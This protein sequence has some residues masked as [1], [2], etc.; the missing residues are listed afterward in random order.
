M[1]L[2]INADDFGYSHEVNEAV[3]RAH[4][5]GV[6]T[7]ASLMAAEPGFDHA[8]ELARRNPTLGVGLHI[9]LTVDHALLP[10]RD[11]PDIVDA[12]GRFIA[13]PFKAALK[14]YFSRAAQQQVRRE[15]EAQFARFAATNLPW[16]HADGHQHFHM[17]IVAWDAMLDLCDAYGVHRLRVPHE[18]LRPHLRH[19]GRPDLNTVATLA[20]RAVRR[21][22]LRVL[23]ERRTLGGKPVFTCERVYG[24]LQTGSMN[25][26]Y[27]RGLLDRLHVP[28]N[29]IYFHPGT[30]H[31]RQLPIGEQRDGIRDVG[32]ASPARS[33]RSRRNHA[34]ATANRN[35]RAGRGM[36]F[37]GQ[38]PKYRAGR[39]RKMNNPR[40]FASA[41]ETRIETAGANRATFH[42]NLIQQA[43]DRL[44]NGLDLA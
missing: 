39:V 13:D 28:T 16:S 3:L 32:T 7:S 34:S 15:M 10:A 17:Q 42:S 26:D 21:R 14:Y 18:E 29:E 43:S 1:F 27:T 20:L 23:K 41:K 2:I 24:Q 33:R 22:N 36:E 30:S 5:E 19:G 38:A 9:A 37:T 8:V 11:L 12:Q 25:T 4:T 44:I 31:A 6:L 35:L 40:P